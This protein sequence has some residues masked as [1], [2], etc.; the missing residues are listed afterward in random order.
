[1]LENGKLGYLMMYAAHIDLGLH[2]NEKDYL[3][4]MLGNEQSLNHILE[5]FKKDD[6]YERIT[7]IEAII[8]E[9][10]P[11]EKDRIVLQLKN[12]FDSDA[13]FSLI[14]RAFLFIFERFSIHNS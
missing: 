2:Q 10:S 1:M 3:N 12:L 4:I 5:E 11:N 13:E 8:S 7:K 14:E 9:I 6:E